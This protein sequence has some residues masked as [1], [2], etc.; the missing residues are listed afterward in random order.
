MNDPKPTIE[1]VA[2]T[3]SQDEDTSGRSGIKFQN[4]HLE[5]I[6]VDDSDDGF[7]VVMNTERWAINDADELRSIIEDFTKRCKNP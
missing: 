2:V 7:Y 5:M 6:R 4:I 3:Y 1:R